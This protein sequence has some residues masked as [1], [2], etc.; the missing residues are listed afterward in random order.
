[1]RVIRLLAVSAVLMF[2]LAPTPAAAQYFGRNKV[3]YVDFD[4]KVLTSEHFDVY[5]Y[6]R[7]EAA[8][9]LAVQLAER[10]YARFSRILNHRFD[11]RQPLVL[12][13]SQAE[14]AQTNVV[15]GLLSDSIG[16]VTEASRRRIVM[17]FAPTMAETNRVLGHEIVHAFQ[18]D[19]ARRHGGG[20]GQ[21]LWFIEGMA[22][23]LARGA[24]DVEAALWLRDAVSSERV[25]V[26]ERDAARRL[27]PYQYGHAMWAYLAQRFGDEVVERA[28]KPGKKDRKLKDRMRHATGVDFDVLFADWRA[29]AMRSEDRGN[30]GHTPL[31][32]AKEGGRMQLGPALSPDGR[33]A[34]FFSERDRLSLDLFLADVETGRVV[35]KLATTA[36]S[37]RFDSLQPLRSAGAWSPNGESF[38]FA[39]VRQG[40]AALTLLDM[41]GST[42]DREIVLKDLGQIFSP[43]WSPDGQAIAFSALAGGFTDLYVYELPTSRLR[44]LT[45]DAFADLHPVWSPDGRSLAFATERYVER[46][47]DAALRADRTGPARSRDWRGAPGDRRRRQPHQSAVVARWPLA[48]FHRRYER[49]AQRASRRARHAGYRRHHRRGHWRQWDDA[50]ES[51][52][53]RGNRRARPR[54]HGLPRRPAAARDNAP[55]LRILQTDR[56]ADTAT[57]EGPHTRALSRL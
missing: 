10:W 20:V 54:L 8:A 35:R 24:T 43:T 23:Y 37:A 42:R 9:R 4:F 30:S 29:A 1:M 53:V 44:R 31:L 36:A 57:A 41:H 50:D 56:T 32:A 48:V 17:P 3:E 13:G 26:K 40:H 55:A 12:Y 47:H 39:A 51:R 21:P 27:S 28:L 18:F 45:E 15:S 16:G 11:R 25:P 52:F 5:Y 19:I 33:Q 38:A 46:S 14:F 7:E 34:V 22:E 6:S 49:N 2:G